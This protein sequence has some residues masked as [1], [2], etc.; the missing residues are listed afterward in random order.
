MP[1]H[2]TTRVRWNSIVTPYGVSVQT[3]ATK[4]GSSAR[5][6]AGEPVEGDYVEQKD[7]EQE[8]S[9]PEDPAFRP[10]VLT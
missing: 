4:D 8:G 6:E 9:V 1:H 10:A 5:L 2:A 3:W 7:D